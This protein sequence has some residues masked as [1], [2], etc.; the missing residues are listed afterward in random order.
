MYKLIRG[1]SKHMD[2]LLRLGRTFYGASGY[3]DAGVAYDEDSHRAHIQQVLDQGLVVVA[4]LEDTEEVV[5]MLGILITPLHLNRKELVATE[6]A[7]WIE[8]EHRRSALGTTMLAFMKDYARRKGAKWWTMTTLEDSPEG[9]DG[10]LRKQGLR[11][12]ERAYL[13]K[14]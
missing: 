9:L 4:T 10:F 5:G 13:G 11:P 14:L 7:W 1:T 12:M 2:D 8:P 6:V 3:E